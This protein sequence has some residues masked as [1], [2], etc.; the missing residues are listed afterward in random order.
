MLTIYFSDEEQ[1]FDQKDLIHD[2][3][4]YFPRIKLTGSEKEL[5]ILKLIENGKFVD[6]LSFIDRFGYKLWTS[7]LST[8]CKA[9]FCVL[10]YPDKVVDLT[11]CGLNARDVIVSVCDVGNVLMTNSSITFVEYKSSISVSL[12]GNKF[13]SVDDLNNYIDDR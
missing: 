11:E 3:E 4:E 7:E 1:L 2:V 6:K 5:E 12:D 8:G 9:A 13:D 10:H